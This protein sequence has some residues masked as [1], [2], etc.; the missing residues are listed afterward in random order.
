MQ[1]RGKK[2]QK[3]Q[4]P[5]AKKQMNTRKRIGKKAKKK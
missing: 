3:V 1:K 2:T 5:N 4:R